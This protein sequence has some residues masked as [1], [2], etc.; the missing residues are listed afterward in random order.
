[1]ATVASMYAQALHEAAKER[2]RVK[3]VRKDLADFAAAA[4][5]VPELRN[6]LRNPQVDPRA[7]AAA[8]GDLLKRPTS[9][10][11]TSCSYSPRKAAAPSSTRSPASSSASSRPRRASSASS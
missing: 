1:M 4:R 10:S 9:S 5:E 3:Q 7:K 2:G 8:L 11:A 6:L